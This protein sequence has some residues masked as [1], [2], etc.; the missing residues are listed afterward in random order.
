MLHVTRRESTLAMVLAAA[1]LGG[2]A[3]DLAIGAGPEGPEWA[4][5]LRV[6][7]GG[8]GF[9][10]EMPIADPGGRERTVLT[11]GGGALWPGS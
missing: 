3:E 9:L 4:A 7:N 11:L 10:G 1:L 2:C 8:I 5:G 6:F